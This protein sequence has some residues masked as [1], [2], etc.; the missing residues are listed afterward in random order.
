MSSE[1]SN[2]AFFRAAL[3]SPERWRR[4]E[5]EGCLLKINFQY[6]LHMPLDREILF[7]VASCAFPNCYTFFSMIDAPLQFLS[8]FLLIIRIH[9]PSRFVIYDSFLRSSEACGDHRARAGHCFE[10]DGR[11]RV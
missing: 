4:I 9:D 10:T 7:H 2:F 11:E 6:F 5:D 1:E 3:P 8:Q